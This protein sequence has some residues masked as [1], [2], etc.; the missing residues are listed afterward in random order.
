[1]STNFILK[2]VLKCYKGTLLLAIHTAHKKRRITLG[3]KNTQ[4]NSTI[5]THGKKKKG[6]HSLLLLHYYN[7]KY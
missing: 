1:M 7:T 6:T 3:E 4:Q 2:A 5:K